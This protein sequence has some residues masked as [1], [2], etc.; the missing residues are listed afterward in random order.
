MYMNF[1]K[2]IKTKHYCVAKT[3]ENKWS[4][5]GS[6]QYK[7]LLKKFM[8]NLGQLKEECFELVLVGKLPVVEMR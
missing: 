8:R 7:V 3:V 6:W 2:L 5:R 4:E 1:G